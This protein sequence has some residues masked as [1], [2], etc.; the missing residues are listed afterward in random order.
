MSPDNNPALATVLTQ[1]FIPCSETT[2]ISAIKSNH[3]LLSE[4]NKRVSKAKC[5]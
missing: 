1:L 2:G 5:E 4:L 3:K